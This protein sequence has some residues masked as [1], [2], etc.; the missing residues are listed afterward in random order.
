MAELTKWEEGSITTMAGFTYP[1]IELIQPG[2]LFDR[3]DLEIEMEFLESV[4]IRVQSWG[5][6]MSVSMP[7]ADA[8]TA[9]QE[10]IEWIKEQVNGGADSVG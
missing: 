6:W 4:T 7:V 2:G 5:K 3:C 10:A 1:H 8:I 9:L